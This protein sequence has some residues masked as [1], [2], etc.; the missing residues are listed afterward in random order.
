MRRPVLSR[1]CRPLICLQS[2]GEVGCGFGGGLPDGVD[3]A[4]LCRP[5]PVHADV[6]SGVFGRELVGIVFVEMETDI[7]VHGRCSLGERGYCSGK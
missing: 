5:L 4:Y 2:G 1:K 6:G 7:V 3:E